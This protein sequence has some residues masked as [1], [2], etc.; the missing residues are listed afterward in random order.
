MAKD[1]CCCWV[2]QFV[3]AWLLLPELV[4]GGSLGGCS[5]SCQ[6]RNNVSVVASDVLLTPFSCLCCF[7][8][9]KGVRGIATIE[10]NTAAWI[11]AVAALALPWWA[12]LCCGQS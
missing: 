10:V 12:Q 4:H 3:N 6:S 1:H 7:L 8:Q 2:R 5:A 11:A 9:I